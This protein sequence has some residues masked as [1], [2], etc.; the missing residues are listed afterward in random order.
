[1]K[2]F[3]FVI[4]FI[5]FFTSNSDVNAQDTARI[6]LL[7]TKYGPIKIRLYDKT[8]LH[9]DNFIKLA[10]EG[11]FNGILFHRC[12]KNFVIQGGDPDSKKAKPGDTLGNGGPGY[13]IPAEFVSE[14]W[15]KRGAV[16]A[17]R[18]NDDINPQRKSSGSQFYIVV[19]KINDD[20]RLDSFEKKYNKKFSPEQRQYYKT[21]GGTPHLDGRYTVFGEVIEGMDVV[22]IISKL[23]TDGND[24]PLEDLKMK[25][26]V[27]K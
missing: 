7:S 2:R 10:K 13:D 4:S 6:V 22:D 17:A 18:E 5:S 3:L 21:F 12:I 23:P 1:M 16:G 19:G 9:R 8:P 25:V 11:Y 20:H 24:R 15:H 26:E 14:Y 27:V